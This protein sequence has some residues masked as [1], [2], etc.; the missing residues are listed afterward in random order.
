M[1][2]RDASDGEATNFG[3][4]WQ[5]NEWDTSIEEEQTVKFPKKMLECKAVG[6]TI[7]FFSEKAIQNFEIVQTMYM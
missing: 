3:L 6:R 1:S 5:N 4:F 7:E 2:L